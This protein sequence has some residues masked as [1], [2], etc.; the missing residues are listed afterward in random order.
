MP[1]GKSFGIIGP[2]EADMTV[3]PKS[4]GDVT[5]S[6][7]Y[8]NLQFHAAGGLGEV[9]RANDESLRREVAIKLIQERHFHNPDYLALFDLEA[10]ITSRLDHPG[11]VPVYGIGRS[12]DKRP[13]YTMRYI[14]G[15]PLR[16]AIEKYHAA[17]AA[18]RELHRLLNHLVAVCNTVAYAHN[19]GIVHCDI[20]PENIMLGK[21]A[22]T[23]LVDWG[24]ATTVERD[25]RAK[26][27]GEKTMR[28]AS[29]SG[30]GKSS[31]SAAG[32]VGYMSPE[33]HPGFRQ[34]ISPAS[35]IY[36]LGA[37]LYCILTNQAP[38][39]GAEDTL[40]LDKLR[41]GQFA[42]P[43]TVNPKIPRALEAICLKAMSTHQA[44][45]YSTA[46]DMAADLEAWLADEPVSVYRETLTERMLRW[47]R[48]NRNW[49]ISGMVA[50]AI[51]VL[52]ASGSAVKLG[53]TAAKEKH[54][55]IDAEQA[56][57]EAEDARAR[58]VVAQ[59]N[60]MRLAAR[61][62]AKAVGNE[63]DLRWRILSQAASDP[64]LPRLMLALKDKVVD[65]PEQRSL[66]HWIES[67]RKVQSP[68]SDSWFLTDQHGVQI[69]R[70]PFNEQTIFANFSERT[71]FH[72]GLQNLT[73][74]EK[75]RGIKPISSPKL[76][77]V[78][79]STAS[80]SLKVA[81]SVPVWK[82]V[83]AQHDC[84]GVLGMSVELGA[85][86]ELQ[87]G[88][89]AGQ[90]AVLVDTR[91]DHVEKSASS[92]LVLHHP[93]LQ[94]AQRRRLA[95]GNS[96]L[97]R[98][99]PQLVER[100]RRLREIRSGQNGQSASGDLAESMDLTYLDPVAPEGNSAVIAA[101]EPVRIESRPPELRDTG[102]VVIVQE[103]S[104][105]ENPAAAK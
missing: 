84:L 19:R 94:D 23:L 27:S 96:S 30:S 15:A 73:P 20:K 48:R 105:V 22:E 81:F 52:V 87:T 42:P 82:D 24:L 88:L 61:F 47:G 8:N 36:S 102:W 90:I 26:A 103:T 65:S 57:R 25:A 59:Q 53:D 13:F 14:E 104:V 44:E 99:G 21:Y 60:G 89:D 72:G 77:S 11:V 70:D 6:A 75:K 62:A 40:L 54:A 1:A 41:W 16:E 63:I 69:A 93:D 33:Q 7:R 18:P 10:E 34:T 50:T 56:R 49:V 43:S 95:A 3:N 51:V 68:D 83:E 92:G 71:Y 74:E 101:F 4:P 85:F 98:I 39:Q 38:L 80:Q 28:I 66:Q 58:A 67:R 32:T 76:S 5:S 64:E 91:Q 29:G 2:I 9:F 100:L 79:L 12:P 31:G 86:Y 17:G 78:Y 55:R 45:R 46:L 35:D 97:F 37:T